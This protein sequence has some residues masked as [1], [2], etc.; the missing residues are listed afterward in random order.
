MGYKGE[1]GVKNL[2]KLVTSFM[3]GPFRVLQQKVLGFSGNT[4]S[5]TI[6][7]PKYIPF[8]DCFGLQETQQIF[9]LDLFVYFVANLVILPK[10]Q[11]V[12]HQLLPLSDYPAVNIVAA[13]I[14]IVAR[15]LL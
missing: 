9:Y 6:M 7:N 4:Q 1:E 3:D 2:K 11:L 8:W 13:V 12:M 5:I 10:H 14:E 15:L